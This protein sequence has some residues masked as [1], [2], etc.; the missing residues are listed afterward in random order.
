MAEYLLIANGRLVMSSDTLEAVHATK[1][2]NP[3]A[4]VYKAESLSREEYD[5]IMEGEKADRYFEAHRKEFQ[6]DSY[7]LI[8]PDGGH[9][10]GEREDQIKLHKEFEEKYPGKVPHIRELDTNSNEII[11]DML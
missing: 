8:N 11:T 5:Y 2:N 9:I 3:Q 6:L 10:S 1:E 7:N 4:I